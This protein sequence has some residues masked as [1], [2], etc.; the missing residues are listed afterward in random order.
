MYNITINLYKKYEGVLAYLKRLCS[1]I[2]K[3]LQSSNLH[4][5]QAMKQ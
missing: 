3:S 1:L 4:I 2:H 5:K